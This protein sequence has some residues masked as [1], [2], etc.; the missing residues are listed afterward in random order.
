MM[1]LH[2]AVGL[3]PVRKKSSLE[4]MKA[5][6]LNPS[7][8]NKPDLPGSSRSK[9]TQSMQSLSVRQG[10]KRRCRGVERKE[11]CIRI[12]IR[13]EALAALNKDLIQGN[14]I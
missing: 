7:K 2:R 9:R 14:V 8:R 1:S 5:E 12:T 10:N 4:A 11:K 3:G 6:P 13:S